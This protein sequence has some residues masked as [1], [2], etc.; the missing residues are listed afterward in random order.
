METEH[1]RGMTV[2]KRG[3]RGEGET[4]GK[5]S[6]GEQLSACHSFVGGIYRQF[7]NLRGDLLLPLVDHD[8]PFAYHLF[9]NFTMIYCFSL[10]GICLEG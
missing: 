2:A 6:K 10:R 3:G 7:L 9:T 5:T 8:L 4:D 1:S